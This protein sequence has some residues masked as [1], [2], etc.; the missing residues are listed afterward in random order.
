MS[1]KSQRSSFLLFKFFST[2][3][4]FVLIIAMVIELA[5]FCQ[6]VFFENFYQRRY[7]FVIGLGKPCRR[8]V[9]FRQA[10][11][12]NGFDVGDDFFDRVLE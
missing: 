2:K 6:Q 8:L 10:G 12:L 5:L 4:F 7:F 3:L 9:Y 11:D 1:E